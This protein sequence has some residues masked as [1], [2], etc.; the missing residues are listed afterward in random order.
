M[1]NSHTSNNHEHHDHEHHDHEHHN[2]EHHE[3]EHHNIFSSIAK[4]L[5]IFPNSSSEERHT[6]A[7]LSSDSEEELIEFT[8]SEYNLDDYQNDVERY[9][10]EGKFPA[11]IA[12]P[13]NGKVCKVRR[14]LLLYNPYSGAQKGKSTAKKATRLLSDAG[15]SVDLY[16]LERGGH[17]QEIVAQEDLSTYDCLCVVGGDGTFH[18][19]INGLM[20][21][22]EEQRKIPIGV[23]PAGTGN[24][25]SLELHG[26]TDVHRAVKHVLRGLY[27]PIDVTKVN[28]GEGKVIYSINSI[29]WGLASA[30]NVRAEKLRWMHSG[31]RYTT[32]IFYEFMKGEKTRAKI[33]FELEDG[34][35]REY[36]EEFCLLIANNIISAKKNQKMAPQ[37]KLNDGLIDIVLIR[38]SN[39]IDLV[40][41]FARTYEGTH[42]EL[43]YVEY[44]Q[45][46]S[47]SV[48]PIKCIVKEENVGVQE[49]TEEII[50]IDG[51]LAGHTPFT[52]T[53]LKQVINVMI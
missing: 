13:S 1:S 38:S 37:A 5:Q 26:G 53:V 9:E 40:K 2:H 47:F 12:L 49:E 32:A 23:I 15:V 7:I 14:V 51:E 25:F 4:K 20:E 50:D 28:Y 33:E 45:V 43:D 3:K 42:T 39:A 21:K 34:T 18:E 22:P 24:S 35:K 48:T 27:C 8:S 31:L 44:L 46:K 6:V 36:D 52:A 11:S 17:A 16:K 41:A 19:A 30:V 29:H 10:K